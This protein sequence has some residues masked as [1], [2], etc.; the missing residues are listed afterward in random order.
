MG[1]AGVGTIGTEAVRE[2]WTGGAC[3]S[4]DLARITQ[5][6]QAFPAIDVAAVGE[7]GAGSLREGRGVV[8]GARSPR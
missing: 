2:R 1:D 6:R 4:G 8:P 5:A 7:A 3:I